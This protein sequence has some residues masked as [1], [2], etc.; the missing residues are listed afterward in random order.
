MTLLLSTWPADRCLFQ[1]LQLTVRCQIRISQCCWNYQYI[2]IWICLFDSDAN[3]IKVCTQCRL[4][5]RNDLLRLFPRKAHWYVDIDSWQMWCNYNI[6]KG[7]VPCSS[8]L[9]CWLGGRRSVVTIKHN[10]STR[11]TMSATSDTKNE[12]HE[13]LA[14]IISSVPNNVL[15]GDFNASL[16]ADH[17][18]WPSCLGQIGV[19][20]MNENGQRMFEP[21]TYHNLCIANS[22]FWTKPQHKVS[23]RHQRSNDWHQFDLIRAALKNVLHTRSH[24]GADCNTDHSL[25]CC[26]IRLQHKRFYRTKKNS[27]SAVLMSASCH[28]QTLWH[29]LRRLLGK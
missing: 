1:Q 5:T 8:V 16:G 12:L 28:D 23:W 26:K 27:G 15:L 13:N 24:H 21:C 2:N 6:T 20:Q 25:L 10:C 19:G 14:A 18:T 17:V 29:N 9:L 3:G 4:C 11:M 22:Y 7:S